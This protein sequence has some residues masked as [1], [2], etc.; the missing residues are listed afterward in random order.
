MPRT[1]ALFTGPWTDLPLETVAAKA[2]EW[3]YQALNVACW[4]EHLAVQKA[5]AEPAYCQS[6]LSM[7]QQHELSIVAL[8]NHPVGQAVSDRL[9]ARH[10]A[11]LPDWVWGDGEPEGVAARAAQEMIDTARAAQQLGVNLVAGSTGSPFTSMLYNTPPITPGILEGCWN[12]FYAAWKPI[13]DAMNQFGCRFACEISPAQ[14][15]FDLISTE[16]TI[17]AFHGHQAFGFSLAPSTLHWQGVD[18]SEFVRL[19]SERLWHVLVQDATITLNGRSSLLGS[20][21]PEGD[22]RRGWNHRALGMGNIDWAALIRTL[23]QVNYS[24]PLTVAIRDHDV[25]RDYAAFQAVDLIRRLDFD[26]VQRDN[27]IFG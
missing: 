6:I 13:L 9:D 17:Q 8:S 3:G 16:Q 12:K 25:D 5:L 18:P 20:L 4:G 21:L 11:S 23:H 26:P 10:Q 19:H 2:G 14:T 24:G 15:V 22:P 27:G 7:L 1:L